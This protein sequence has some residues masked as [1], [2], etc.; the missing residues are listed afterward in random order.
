LDDWT[1][2]KPVHI[3]ASVLPDGR[4]LLY[5]SQTREAIP[6]SAPAGI[7][8]ELCDGESQLPHILAELSHLY[9]DVPA[10]TLLSQARETLAALVAQGLLDA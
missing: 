8:W 7:L 4:W 10:D 2:S 9:P 1:P 6:L 5:N 3:S